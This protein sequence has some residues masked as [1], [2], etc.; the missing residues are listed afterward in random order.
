[1]A[2]SQR[3]REA[4]ETRRILEVKKRNEARLA[5]MDYGAWMRQVAIWREM[6]E[7]DKKHGIGKYRK[8]GARNPVYRPKRGRK[9]WTLYSGGFASAR[10]S[11]PPKIRQGGHGRDDLSVWVKLKDQDKAIAAALRQGWEY[12]NRTVYLAQGTVALSFKPKTTTTTNPRS[13][14]RKRGARNPL[15]PSGYNKIQAAP[16]RVWTQCKCG[17]KSPKRRPGQRVPTVFFTPFECPKCGRV[18]SDFTVHRRGRNPHAKKAH[19]HSRTK[20][21]AGKRKLSVNP[22]SRRKVRRRRS[23]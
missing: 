10:L 14:Y 17:W 23:R 19:A 4:R 16:H 22:S 6:D 5:N 9:P 1:M 18:L 2:L 13:K 20:R 8:R 12:T 21:A 15:E 7:F 3:E 11:R